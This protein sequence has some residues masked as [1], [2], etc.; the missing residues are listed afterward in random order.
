LDVAA[1][2]VANASTPGYRADRAVFRA[3]LSQAMGGVGSQSMKYAIVR[4]VEPD[5]KPGS[6]VSTGRPLDVALSDP[7]TFF[8]VSTSQGERYTRAGNITMAADG[9]LMTPEGLPYLGANRKPL[10]VDPNL[11]QLSI[12]PNGALT[13]EGEPIGPQ[14]AVVKFANP[15]ALEK[16][17]DVLLRARPGA[18]PAEN[19]DPRVEPGALEMSNR[20]AL[21]SITGMVQ[22]TRQFDM[23]SRVI[24]AFSQADRRA[25]KDIIGR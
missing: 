21:R 11:H 3:T 22:T 2:N 15:R 20:H 4:S 8:V 13:A 5:L 17:G 12:G 10:K 24:E 1:N 25:A 23:L 18:G 16:E 9:T 19:A 14:L 6:L 7:D